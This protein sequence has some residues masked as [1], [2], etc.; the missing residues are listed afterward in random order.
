[1]ECWRP[2][3]HPAGEKRKQKI[4]LSIRALEEKLNAEALKKYGEKGLSSG[5][6][7]PFASLSDKLEKKKKRN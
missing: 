1:M 3:R 6:S 4:S 7:L 5:K 2:S